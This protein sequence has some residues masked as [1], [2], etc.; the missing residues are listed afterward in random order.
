[1]NDQWSVTLLIQRCLSFQNV[2]FYV[3]TMLYS[4][5]ACLLAS[6]RIPILKHP[7][8]Y[9]DFILSKQTKKQWFLVKCWIEFSVLQQKQNSGNT[10]TLGNFSAPFAT[11][12]KWIVKN[13]S[14]LKQFHLGAALKM[15]LSVLLKRVGFCEIK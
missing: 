3:N 8:I 13:E 10:H 12:L 4:L 2:F 6:F 5:F 7:H 15:S 9:N 11:L 1:M 14:D